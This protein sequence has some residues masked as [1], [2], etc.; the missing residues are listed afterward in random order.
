M[1]LQEMVDH[2]ADVVRRPALLEDRSQRTVVYSPQSDAID[3]VRRTTILRRHTAPDVRSWLQAIG[4][5]TAR[6]P[7]RTP[8]NHRLSMLPRLCVPIWK[9]EVPLGY[10]W[11]IESPDRMSTRDVELAGGYGDDLAH[12]WYRARMSQDQESSRIASDA[13]DLILGSG[14]EMRAAADRLID[15]GQIAPGATIRVLTVQPVVD[16]PPDA[17]DDLRALVEGVVRGGRQVAGVTKYLG[18]GQPDHGVIVLSAQ[19]GSPGATADQVAKRVAV[20]AER[21]AADLPSVSRVVV[22]V[23]RARP[24]PDQAQDSY[25]EACRAARIAVSFQLESPVV[26]WDRLGV[27]RG[28]FTIAHNGVQPE[29]LQ[30]GISPL[31]GEKDGEALLDTLECYLNLGGNVQRAAAQLNLHR[32]SLYYRLDRIQ[33]ITGVDL[34]DGV[35]RLGLHLAVLLERMDRRGLPGRRR[36]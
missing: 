14:A 18:F 7:L 30:T 20:L 12:E 21:A 13:R 15:D 31:L 28:L 22:G 16:D 34:Q 26:H 10:L 8:E 5:S 2:I 35:Q 3:D 6:E 29:D 17:P 19:D 27:Y 24:V 33:R 11:F 25:L 4:L 9:A 36:G 1:G 23:G 32:T